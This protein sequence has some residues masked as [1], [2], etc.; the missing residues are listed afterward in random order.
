MTCPVCGAE[1]AEGRVACWKCY[2]P[3]QPSAQAPPGERPTEAPSAVPTLAPRARVAARSAVSGRTGPS[4]SIVLIVVVALVAVTVVAGGVVL[5]RANPPDKVA[6]DFLTSCFVKPSTEVAKGL[7]VSSQ[8]EK[9]EGLVKG[10]ETAMK[11]ARQ[12][13]AGDVSRSL[14]L[15]VKSSQV[16]GGQ[17]TVTVSL[18]FSDPRNPAFSFSLDLPVVVV[19]E[20][21]FWW[22]VDL[23]QTSKAWLQSVTRTFQGLPMPPVG[24]RR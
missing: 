10:T 17:G 14:Q 22:K 4:A 16:S 19:R 8:R 1:N 11:L 23:D 15:S 12:M 3:L 2:A 6:L 9:V 7:V 18:K 13:G 24:G 21:L 20:R 5:A